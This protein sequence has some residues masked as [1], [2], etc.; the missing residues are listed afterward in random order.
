M[1]LSGRY[2]APG[3]FVER[4]TITIEGDRITAVTLAED[5]AADVQAGGGWIAP[6]F[7][8]L[9]INGSYG[10]DIGSDPGSLPALAE[11]MPRQGVTTFLPTVVTSAWESYPQTL[12]TLAEA[13]AQAAAEG[14]GALT[15]GAH[16]EG[17]FLSPLFKGAH[18]PQYLRR[19][20]ADD[21]R[22]FVTLAPTALLT[23]APELPGALEAIA[24]I[25]PLVSAGHSAAGYDEARR[26]FGQGVT[27][28]T[29]LYNAMAPMTH[30]APGLVGAVLTTPE[31]RCGVIADGVHVHPAMVRLAYQCKGAGG[32]TLVTDAITAAGLPPGRYPH[33]GQMIINDGKAAR[34]PE[35]G[36]LAG[37]ILTMDQAIRNMVDFAGCRPEEA[38]RMASE[39]PA[40]VLR[41]TDSFGVLAPG[42]LANITVLGEDLHVRL[43]IVRG[44]ALYER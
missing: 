28:V 43:T 18:L 13:M 31:V 33:A 26:A 11:M 29:H 6:G 32:I 10:Y 19:P 5:A 25:A 16:L 36:V 38:L 27:Y 34:L 17:P 23:L 14:R 42:R 2:V 44:K 40:Q 1:K 37:S 4:G 24:G 30:R 35:S 12:T 8:E 7:V 20:T 21:V 3:G 39:T 9:Q 41:A 22:R 15:P